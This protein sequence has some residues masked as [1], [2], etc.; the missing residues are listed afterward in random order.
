MAELFCD[1]VTLVQASIVAGFPWFPA[2]T[3]WLPGK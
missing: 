1:F 2:P 3:P